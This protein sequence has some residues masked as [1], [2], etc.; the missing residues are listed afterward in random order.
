MFCTTLGHTQIF[1]IEQ[2]ATFDG[3]LSS[4]PEYESEAEQ[5]FVSPKRRR[6]WLSVR[7]LLHE[8]LGH[9]V[10]IVYNSANRPHLENSPLQISI[11]HSGIHAAIALSARPTGL[12]IEHA[13]QKAG[14]LLNRFTTKEERHHLSPVEIWCAKEAVYKLVPLAPG[15]LLTDIHI[16]SPER[17]LCQ[18]YEANLYFSC[19]NGMHIC[20][21]EEVKEQ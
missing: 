7:L 5:R 1:I 14:L 20:V 17:A 18:G 10:R 9:H 3:L 4:F 21:A 12:D 13:A 8:I 16:L 19:Y 2:P 15:T 11:A 6:E